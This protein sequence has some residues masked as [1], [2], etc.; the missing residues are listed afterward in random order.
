M[1]CHAVMR[2]VMTG[3]NPQ[4]ALYSADH[5]HSGPRFFAARVNVGVSW[6]GDRL[7]MNG[8]CHGEHTERDGELK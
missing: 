7:A 5:V 1:I 3:D 4:A 6:D 2:H 8:C